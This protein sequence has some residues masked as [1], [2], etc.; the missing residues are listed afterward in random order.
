MVVS[1]YD[2]V[3]SPDINK[4]IYC[5][6]RM[7]AVAEDSFDEKCYLYKFVNMITS[8]RRFENISNPRS[9]HET[10]TLKQAYILGNSDQAST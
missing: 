4:R 6:E 3:L 7:I 1:V 9:K 8:Y 2:S 10:K 5:F